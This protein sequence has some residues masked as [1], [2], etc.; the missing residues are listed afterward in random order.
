M[1]NYSF[2]KKN[3]NRNFIIIY[4]VLL[5]ITAIAIGMPV[6]QS[7]YIYPRFEK[8]LFDNTEN[9]VARTGKHMM[10]VVLKSYTGGKIVISDEIKT[11]F[12]NT[13][14]DFN[15]GKIKILSHSGET[16][17]STSGEEIGAINENTYFRDIVSKGKT[18]TRIVN[19]SARS[20]E[21]QMVDVNMIETYVPIINGGEFLGAFELY[22]DITAQK[23]SMI[24]LI[25]QF[26]LL[27]YFSAII[28][29]NLVVLTLII[30]RDRMK[31]RQKF[32]NTLLKMA[33]TDELTGL[34]NRR[35]FEEL[36]QW[37]FGKIERHQRKSCILL[38]DIDHFKK[39]NDT[40]GHQAGDNVLV[41][42]AQ[43]CKGE[44]RKSDILCRYGGEEFIALL[45]DTN[46]ESALKVAEK[47][48]WAI[49]S[50][51]FSTPEGAIRITISIGVVSFGD[52]DKL[53]FDKVIKYADDSLYFAKRNGRNQTFCAQ[54]NAFLERGNAHYCKG[55]YDKAISDYNKAI[56]INPGIARAYTNRGLA[57]RR[58]GQYDKAIS[59]YN[60]AIE[61]NPKIAKA[62]THR[63]LAYYFK[64]EFDH[65]WYDVKKAQILGCQIHPG[66][67]RAL[68]EASDR[69]RKKSIKNRMFANTVKAHEIT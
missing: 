14:R 23:K 7:H 41:T 10:R 34:Y 57:Y 15:L 12:N 53:S 18:Y 17:Y 30:F 29:I 27:L 39:V 61:I 43:K 24:A 67:L 19:K 36:L 46:L 48:R 28:I 68:R 50:T 31:E 54:A 1:N 64:K 42:V 56:E 62:Y 37:E 55:Q 52:T 33:N 8:Q 13:L 5:L 45:P 58:K 4:L 40:Y 63:G 44:L 25:S 22:Y 6:F 20:I 65:A 32:E 9:E 3:H 59:D 16:V 49:E 47:L 66:F 38:F 26:N 35:R 2:D 21:N 11:Y 60:K 69:K 51:S